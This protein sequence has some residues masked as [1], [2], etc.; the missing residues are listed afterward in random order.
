[1][2]IATTIGFYSIVQKEHHDDPDGK[3]L[4]VVRA[5]ARDDLQRLVDLIQPK[6]KLYTGDKPVKI[7]I[8][9]Y[10]KSDYK[11]RIYLETKEDFE[12]TLAALAK[13]VTYPNFKDEILEIDH[14]RDKVQ[15]YSDLWLGLLLS[16]NKEAFGGDF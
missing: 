11:Y 13:T 1:M 12:A 8:Y 7:K 15:P 3:K 2:W 9:E 16:H 4:F 14:Q 5:R 6:L 10:E